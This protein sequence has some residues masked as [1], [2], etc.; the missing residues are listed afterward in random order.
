MDF[1][2][3]FSPPA[4]RPAWRPYSANFYPAG[5]RG[6]GVGFCY[7]FGRV[8]SAT[9]PYLVGFLGDRIGLGPAIGIDAGFAYLLVV[10]A[11]IMLP[12]MRGK[13][14]DDEAVVAR[15]GA[16]RPGGQAEA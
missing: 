10:V 8:L 5:L 2:S 13:V 3:G 16:S 6:T 11:I 7:N 12:E 14:L 15:L 4:S 1:R 9:F